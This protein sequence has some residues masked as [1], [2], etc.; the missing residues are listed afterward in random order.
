MRTKAEDW[1]ADTWE[2]YSWL[3]SE[4]GGAMTQREVAEATGLNFYWIQDY[5]KTAGSKDPGVKKCNALYNL[6]LEMSE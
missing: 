5:A 4:D 1:V 2:A 6:Y 3:V